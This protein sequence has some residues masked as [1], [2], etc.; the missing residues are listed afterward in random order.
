VTVERK[1]TELSEESIDAKVKRFTSVK[2]VVATIGV[3]SLPAFSLRVLSVSHYDLNTALALLQNTP[4]VSFIYA[5][6]MDIT[7]LLSSAAGAAILVLQQRRYPFRLRQARA[8]LAATSTYVLSLLFSLPALLQADIGTWPF[9]FMTPLAVVFFDY[10]STTYLVVMLSVL[11]YFLT[12]YRPLMWLPPENLNVDGKVRTLYVLQPQDSDLVVFDPDQ[13]TVVRIGKASVTSRVYCDYG[14][15]G[16]I[17]EIFLS[18]PTGRP[19]CA[20]YHPSTTR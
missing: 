5:N 3:I 14:S 7:P 15:T 9:V 8:W 1:K 16:Q 2:D 20:N 13:R 18:P 4:L 12:I 10:A 6:V 19:R 11:F 17:S